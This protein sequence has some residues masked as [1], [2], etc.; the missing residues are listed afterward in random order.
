MAKEQT[1]KRRV[2][3]IPLMIQ[4]GAG[5]ERLHLTIGKTLVS[6]VAPVVKVGAIQ[7]ARRL[8]I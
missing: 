3:F 4:P 6:A 1:N 8:G 5:P 2:L 7:A